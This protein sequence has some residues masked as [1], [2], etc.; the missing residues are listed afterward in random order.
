M[1]TTNRTILCNFVAVLLCAVVIAPAAQAASSYFGQSDLVSRG[2]FIRTAMQVLKVA[3][4]EQDS[5]SIPYSRVPASMRPYIQAAHDSNALGAF[6]NDLRLAYP[7]TRG[8]ALRFVVE[9]FGKE[10][11][12]SVQFRDVTKG[13]MEERAV[14][15]AIEAEWMSP[16][17]SNFFGFDRRLTGPAADAFVRSIQGI[18][19]SNGEDAGDTENKVPTIRVQ[20]RG[21]GIST[22]S[23]IPNAKL[24]NAVWKIIRS[25]YLYQEKIDEDAATY[26]ALESLVQSLQDPYSRFMRPRSAKNFQT[27]ID[28]EVSGIGAQVEMRGEYLTI[29]TPLPGS[30]AQKAN[31][32]PNDLII[33][34][35]GESIVGEEF[36]NAVEKV[37][38]PIGSSVEL[39]INRSGSVFTV[40][41]VRNK[42]RVPEIDISWNG[43]VAVVKLMQ[44]GKLTDAELRGHMAKIQEQDPRGIILDVRNNPGGLLHAASEVVSN[45]VP[46]GS[47]VAIIKTRE[48]EHNALTNEE[49][50]IDADVPVVVLVNAGSASASEIVAGALQDHKRATV[51]GETSFG[52]GTVQE[53]LE[54][55]DESSLKLTIAEW[56]TPDGRKIDGK[57][58]EPDIEVQYESERDAQMLR[59]LDILRR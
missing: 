4:P 13:T 21:Q 3:A 35:N 48:S 50:T 29:V 11:S 15:V 28:G 1:R 2:T 36:M 30:P 25:D 39:T 19:S 58:V 34:V 45:F 20:M 8:E 56:L 10:S 14:R 26:S 32:K 5:Y 46:R 49:P 40:D 23:N 47:S 44:F 43:K 24:I 12:K 27:Q 53:V 9:L 17:R 6:G 31:L 52:K 41:V 54:F 7:I 33:A 16:M 22:T 55:T 51:V 18:S 59:A 42:V 38:G 57:G 37:R